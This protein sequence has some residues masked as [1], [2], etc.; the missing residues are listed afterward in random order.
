MRSLA[1]L[2][3]AGL[4]CL[5]PGC[6]PQ[7][8]PSPPSPAPAG[9][10]QPSWRLKLDVPEFIQAGKPVD[11]ALRIFDAAGQPVEQADVEASLVMTTM[12]MG[13]NKAKLTETQ[14]GIYT[15][16]GTFSMAGTWEVVA[17]VNKGGAII[18]QRFPCLV[19]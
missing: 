17:K 12:D 15:G 19:R 10:P 16:K 8:S 9:A 5:L 11:L 7:K 13:E 14:P 2:L 18:T 6:S 4:V 3:L 1:C